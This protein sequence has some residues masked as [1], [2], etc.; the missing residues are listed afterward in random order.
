MRGAA[1]IRL[2]ALPTCWDRLGLRSRPWKIETT[3]IAILVESPALGLRLTYAA[4][5]LD[6]TADREQDRGRGGD[7]PG[8]PA[9]LLGPTRSSIPPLERYR[10][11]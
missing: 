9:D 10:R 5:F 11:S 2:G 1:G 8:S 7:T 4:R 3:K 6:T